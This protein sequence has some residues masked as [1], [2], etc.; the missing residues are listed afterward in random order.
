MLV[1][2]R[3]NL[4][5]YLHTILRPKRKAWWVVGA[6]KYRLIDAWVGGWVSVWMADG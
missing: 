3:D 6:Q 2:D 1:K 5:F 4:A